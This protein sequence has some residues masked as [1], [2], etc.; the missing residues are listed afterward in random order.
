MVPSTF[1]R[2]EH[3]PQFQCQVW[4]LGPAVTMEILY[5]QPSSS[6]C[7]WH[8]MLSLENI[9]TKTKIQYITIRCLSI[10][11]L[12]VCLL[13]CLFACTAIALSQSAVVLSCTVICNLLRHLASFLKCIYLYFNNRF[14]LADVNNFSLGP[15][16][17]CRTS[18][19]FT[20]G[21]QT[22]RSTAVGILASLGRVKRWFYICLNV[23]RDFFLVI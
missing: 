20:L 2:G 11:C 23:W 10:V 6:L 15:G 18:L 9:F 3:Y 4:L 7:L 13:A 5:L 1:W 21:W 8:V 19:M 12:F 16:L 22:N 14:L 17:K